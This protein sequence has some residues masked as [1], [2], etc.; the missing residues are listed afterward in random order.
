MSPSPPDVS[1]IIQQ[2]HDKGI[3]HNIDLL[4]SRMNGTTDG[5]VYTLTEK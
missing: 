5:L 4:I 2:L 3:I 1:I